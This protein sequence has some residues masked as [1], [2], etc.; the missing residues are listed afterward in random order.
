MNQTQT[1]VDEVILDDEGIET[2]AYRFQVD[3]V[4]VWVD[5]TPLGEGQSELVDKIIL[6]RK[7]H[8]DLLGML[9]LILK[10]LDLEPV[11]DIFP[12]SA[13]RVD[14]RRVIAEAE[15]NTPHAKTCDS[16]DHLPDDQTTYTQLCR[17]C[18]TGGE[19]AA[20]TAKPTTPPQPA[21][22]PTPQDN[23]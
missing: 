22:H 14:I 16:C 11:G 3:D 4:T 12:C 17:D 1:K 21:Q 5:A 8:D 10:R 15:P 7:C 18:I 23:A 20:W 19:F 6:A 9:E 13:M 2:V